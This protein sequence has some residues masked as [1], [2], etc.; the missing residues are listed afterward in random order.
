MDAAIFRECN[1]DYIQG[2]VD[3]IL[4]YH[5]RLLRENEGLK[6]AEKGFFQFPKITEPD[7]IFP[8]HRQTFLTK[9][10]LWYPENTAT[11]FR[12]YFCHPGRSLGQFNR[13]YDEL[14]TLEWKQEY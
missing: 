14:A 8:A 5:M 7:G 13:M 4:L 9:N 11:L 1:H 12:R 10:V 2:Y 6:W 3:C